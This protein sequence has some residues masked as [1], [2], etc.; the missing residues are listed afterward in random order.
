MI[1]VPAI[2]L[3]AIQIVDDLVRQESGWFDDYFY[4]DR[5]TDGSIAR[6]DMLYSHQ[7]LGWEFYLQDKLNNKDVLFMVATETHLHVIASKGR[8]S[9]EL[10]NPNF[11]TTLLWLIRGLCRAYLNLE[12]VALRDLANRKNSY[13]ALSTAAAHIPRRRAAL[14]LLDPYFAE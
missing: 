1:P 3:A 10:A 8:T 13:P 11:E 4:F 6:R 7:T 12:L 2:V 5:L 14:A 9:L